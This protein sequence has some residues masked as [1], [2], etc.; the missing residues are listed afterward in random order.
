MWLARILAR[1]QCVFLPSRLDDGPAR[2]LSAPKNKVSDNKADF[3][4]S[5]HTPSALAVYTSRDG[6]PHHRARLAPGRWRS[7]T[8]WDILPPGSTSR[9]LICNHYISS[10]LTELR[11][12]LGRAARSDGTPKKQEKREFNFLASERL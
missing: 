3:R 5:Y 2:T 4:G 7:F 10:S 12:V 11:V 1:K 6:S 9:F 8:V